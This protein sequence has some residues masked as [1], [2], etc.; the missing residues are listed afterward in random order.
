MLYRY[1]KHGIMAHGEDVRD[2]HCTVWTEKKNINF[3]WLSLRI[4]NTLIIST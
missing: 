4:R 1:I 2:D 3:D